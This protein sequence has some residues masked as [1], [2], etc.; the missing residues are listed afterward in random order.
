M[1][2]QTRVRPRT[3]WR[4]YI[5]DAPCYGACKTIKGCWKPGG[6]SRLPRSVSS[7]P[8]RE[9]KWVRKWEKAW[10]ATTDVT[11]TT[12]IH[13]F[14]EYFNEMQKGFCLKSQSFKHL[15]TLN[16]WCVCAELSG[17]R[18]WIWK[19]CVMENVCGAASPCESLQR[20]HGFAANNCLN[21]RC[22]IHLAVTL[23]H[24]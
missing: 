8:S 12:S 21:W 9:E 4:D 17:K 13:Y 10:E 16:I 14:A 15:N 6:V 19:T 20:K 2:K 22:K 5:S 7:R 24:Q 3:R 1:G 11:E 23:V 18:V